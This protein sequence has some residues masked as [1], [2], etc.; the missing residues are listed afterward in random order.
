MMMALITT[1]IVLLKLTIY[2]S[3]D[4]VATQVLL[5]IHTHKNRLIARLRFMHLLG[6]PQS[7]RWF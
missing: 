1:I 5:H 6:P 2:L 4:Q 7:A 3:D